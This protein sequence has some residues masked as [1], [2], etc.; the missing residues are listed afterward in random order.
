MKFD[1]NDMII[2]VFEGEDIYFRK[3]NQSNIQY[4]IKLYNRCRKRF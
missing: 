1:I 2:K 4:Q 3:N